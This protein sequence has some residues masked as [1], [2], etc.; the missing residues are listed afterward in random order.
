MTFTGTGSLAL[1]LAM[2]AGMF[3]TG[4]VV[5]G[6]LGA[7]LPL[8][9][10]PLL[11]LIMPAP[12]AIGLLVLPVLLSN[13]LQAVEGGRLRVAMRGFSSLMLA[14]LVGTLLAVQLSQHLSLKEINGAIA[15]TVL[16]AVLVMVFQ[17]RGAIEARHRVWADPLVGAIAGLM[18]GVSSLT[19]PILITYLMALRLPRDEF[20]GSISIIYLVGALPMYGAMLAWGRFGWTEVAW[21]CLALAPVYLGMRFGG[22]LRHRLSEIVFQ[23]LL[24]AFLL[25]LSVMLVVK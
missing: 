22:A 1:L 14:Q 25:A 16:S 18:A 20:V 11:S 23:R 8:V 3:I 4:G 12:Q 5:K 6:T 17:P 10:V 15:L 19:G 9:V 2:S 7:G 21:S 24:L 13:L